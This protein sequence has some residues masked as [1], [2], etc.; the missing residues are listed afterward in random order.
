M[1]TSKEKSLI[2][3]LEEEPFGGCTLRVRRV[4]HRVIGAIPSVCLEKAEIMT[5]VFK[6][7]EGEPRVIRQAKAFRELCELKSISIQDDELIVGL[8]GSK[9]RAGVLNPDTDYWIL[10]DELDSISTR[11]QDPY[12]ITEEQ[13]VLFREYIEPYWKGRTFWDVWNTT[14]PEDLHQLNEAV[15]ACVLSGKDQ[16]GHSLFIPDYELVLKIGISGIRQR[17]N[18]KLASLDLAIPGHFEKWTYLNAL[19]T[20]C[21]GIEKLA[22]RYAALALEKAGDEKDPIRKVE[23]ERIAEICRKVP[24]QPADTFWEAL[25]SFWLYHV[26]LNIEYS[27]ASF[28]PGRMDQ[29]LYPYYKKEIEEGKISKEQAQELLEILWVKFSEVM[30][31]IDKGYS[32]FAP[33]Y[34]RFQN[35]VCGGVTKSGQDGV[36]E[37]SYMM[38]QSAMDIRLSQPNLSVKFNKKNPELLLRKAGELAGLGTGQPQFYNDEVGTKYLMELDLPFDDAYNWGTLGCKDLGLAGKIG[39]V[40]VPT[41]V[42][43]GAAMEMALLNGKNRRSHLPVPQT[44][45]PRS[46]KTY[47]EFKEAVK[48]L[49]AY[50]IKKAAEIALIIEVILQEQSPSLLTSLSYEECIE[51]AKDCMSGGAKYNPGPEIVAMGLADIVNSLSVIK[52]LIYEDKK[53]TWDK[54]LKALEKDFAGYEDIR[55]M[56]LAVPKFG[57]DI[58]EIDRVATEISRFVGEEARR[59]KGLYGGKRILVGTAAAG[60]LYNGMAVG[61]LP[62]GRKAWVPL[63]D[64]AS[65]MQGTDKNGPTAVLNSISKCSLD[66]YCSP[67]LNMKLDPLLFKNERGVENFVSL[68]KSWHDLG[69]YHIQFNVVSPEIL[70]NAQ[71]QPEEYQGLMVR[72]S[73]YCA[74]YIDLNTDIQNDIIERTTFVTAN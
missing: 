51:N 13:K 32:I 57:N 17:I 40:R 56:C 22:G 66:V 6:K 54:L 61:A 74:R 27:C 24:L 44:G 12:L 33:G 48:L 35:V 60:H 55:D 39:S 8:P 18:E 68:V 1:I 59:Y 50:Q 47:E 52:K 2:E 34:A 58:P 43:M 5:G 37:L 26:C 65:P 72:V 23:L 64:G 73:G 49:L 36:N 29:Y 28:N 53:L 67:L 30:F 70:R 71:K 46:F 63:A 11:E 45:D 19:L 16:S 7:T 31:I 62:S 20:V 25:Q 14:A 38:I 4:R 10:S 21:E 15:V 42:N 41:S 3:K 9:T 69:I